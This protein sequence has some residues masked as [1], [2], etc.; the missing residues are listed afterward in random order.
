MASLY[1]HIP[2]CLKKCLY[3]AFSSCVGDRSLQ[4]SYVEA[5]KKELYE[6][7]KRAEKKEESLNTL[8][9]GGGTPTCLA[10]DDLTGLLSYC[11]EIFSVADGAEISVETNPGTVDRN[12]LER[13]LAAGVNRLS[14]GVQSFDDLQLQ[15]LGR[16]HSSKEA[17][18]VICDAKK[19]GFTNCN[20][21]LMYGLPGQPPSSWRHTLETAF[22]VD[23]KH[24]SLYQLTVEEGTALFNLVGK[25]D[26][27]LPTEDEV[28]H[29]DEITLSLCAQASYEQYEVS[30]FCLEGF[31]CKH[32]INYWKNN[33]YYGAGAAAVSY[34][35]GCR[36]KRIQSPKAYIEAVERNISTTEECEVLEPDESFRETVIMGLR[37][38]E[39]VCLQSL[40]QRYG[41][42]PKQYYGV[43]LN[44]LVKQ[45]LVGLSQTHLYITPKGWPLSNRIMAELV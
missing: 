23:P 37:M 40:D 34:T 30:N 41:I 6:V 38:V 5:V 28:L 2:F 39:G 14:L 4:K 29:M 20:V 9:V 35:E 18:T 8:F 15:T 43:T 45:G 33:D 44:R 27:E 17:W 16:A 24:L 25:G 11:T 21:D 3:C 42:D 32:N 22:L 13:L 26:L 10:V 7:A 1:I 31:R 12:Y 36:K 19:E